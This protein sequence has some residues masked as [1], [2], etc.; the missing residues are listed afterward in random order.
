[1]QVPCLK[2]YT[3]SPLKVVPDKENHIHSG[4]QQW[5]AGLDLASKGKTVTSV[6]PGTRQDGCWCYFFLLKTWLHKEVQ[7]SRW[8][9]F[10][11]LASLSQEQPICPFPLLY[12]CHQK[13]ARDSVLTFILLFNRD[14]AEEKVTLQ[15]SPFAA[16][17][18]IISSFPSC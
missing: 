9:P 16:L 4:V 13:V 1:M 14:G 3:P 7:K 2:G 8:T 15:S 6:L 10:I 12:P 11:R 5:F 17:S 18:L